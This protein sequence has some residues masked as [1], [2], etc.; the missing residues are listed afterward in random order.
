M[1]IIVIKILDK[2][3]ESMLLEYNT[4]GN[5][6]FKRTGIRLRSWF[7]LEERKRF[8]PWR[9]KTKNEKTIVFDSAFLVF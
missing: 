9:G 4:A 1:F 8:R 6:L 7:I 3:R 5:R 2:N